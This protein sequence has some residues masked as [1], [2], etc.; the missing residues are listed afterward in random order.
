MQVCWCL[1]KRRLDST[2]FMK[3]CSPRSIS[4]PVA[5]FDAEPPSFGLG[6]L[7]AGVLHNQ[8][9]VIGDA[10]LLPRQ[11]SGGRALF[12]G[13]MAFLQIMMKV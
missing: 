6:M 4:F 2:Q 13:M 1:I 10:F 9:G 7:L 8:V 11:D 3:Y 12:L 5:I